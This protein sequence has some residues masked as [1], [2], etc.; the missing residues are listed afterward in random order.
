MPDNLHPFRGRSGAIALARTFKQLSAVLLCGLLAACSQDDTPQAL[1]TLERDRLLLTATAAEFITDQPVAEGSRVE[2]GAVIVQLDTTRQARAV[3]RAQAEV[4]AL[5]ATLEKLRNGPRPEEL[6]AAEARRDN[7]A[8]ALAESDKE[9]TRISDLTRQRLASQAELDTATARRDGNAAQLRDTGAQ[10]ALLQ[11]GSRSEDIALTQA[12][13]QGAQAA[14]AA[15]QLRL[16]ELTLRA[17]R[18]ALLDSLPWEVGERVSAGT[19]V[20]ILL[21]PGAPYARLYLPETRRAGMAVGATVQVLV[22]GEAA[23][24]QGTVRWISRDPAF[25][26]YYALNGTERTR[27]VYLMEV[28]LPDSAAALPAGL[29]AQLLLP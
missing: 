1:G 9:L 11:A 5:D 10:L 19:P 3:E 7:A 22:D 20:A 25:T 28:D 21:E 8:V 26:P 27:L 15:E 13:L 18:A 2:A 17:P 14:L 23:P 12:Q 16:E 4:R 24:L 6:A 29:P